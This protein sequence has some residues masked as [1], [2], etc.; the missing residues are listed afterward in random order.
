[1]T[2]LLAIEAEKVKARLFFI[3]FVLISARSA[4]AAG[5]SR[6]GLGGGNF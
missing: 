2:D 5:E 4:A 1:L 3:E 6:D